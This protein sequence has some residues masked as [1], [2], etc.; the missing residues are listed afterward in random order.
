MSRDSSGLLS[1]LDVYGAE[2]YALLTRVTLRS[3]VA[4]DLLQELFLKLRD[5]AGLARA[6]NARAY[7]FTAA[8]HL[9]F[10]WR[11]TRKPLASLDREPAAPGSP[12]LERMIQAEEFEQVLDALDQLS[13]LGRQVVVLRYLQHHEYR[14]IAQ[15]L[16]K[17]EHQVRA[18]CSKAISQLQTILNPV[19]EPG[20]RGVES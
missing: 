7:V 20:E 13:D 9:A 11:R 17:T 18:L 8:I 6:R 14:Q 5:S 4:E 1:I 15:E 3:D 19:P 12:V 10:D 16:G 2:L